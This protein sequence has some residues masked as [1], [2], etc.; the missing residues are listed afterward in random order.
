MDDVTIDSRLRL[1]QQAERVSSLPDGQVPPRLHVPVRND[2]KVTKPIGYTIGI[3][4]G[5][6]SG[7][8]IP[9]V[10]IHLIPCYQDD[11]RA[12]RNPGAG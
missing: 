1:I 10:H 8:S 11:R 3:N 7:R 6:G 2:Q 9:H 4:E 12:V 5:T